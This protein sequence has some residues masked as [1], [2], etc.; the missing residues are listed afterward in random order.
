LAVANMVCPASGA[1]PEPGTHMAQK[2]WMNRSIQD[3][4]WGT[5][6]GMVRYKAARAG[7]ALI[8]VDA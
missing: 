1:M 8:L 3:A 6:T 2:E 4:G 5:L 7:A